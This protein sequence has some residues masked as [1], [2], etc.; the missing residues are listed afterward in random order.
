MT[1]KGARR[2]TPCSPDTPHGLAEGFEQRPGGAIGFGPIFRV[3][4]DADGKALGIDDGDGLDGA[5]FG[6]RFHL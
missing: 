4:L 6:G 1:D 5:V 2:F 3:P